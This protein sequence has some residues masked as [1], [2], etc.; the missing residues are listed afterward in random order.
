MKELFMIYT[1]FRLLCYIK[2]FLLN[3]I[4]LLIGFLYF[5]LNRKRHPFYN[6]E[7]IENYK[8]KKILYM[9]CLEENTTKATNKVA[10]LNFYPFE[11]QKMYIKKSIVFKYFS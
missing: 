6:R 5:Y 7:S 9:V 2:A 4:F 10:I 3:L 1:Q 8:N 11:I